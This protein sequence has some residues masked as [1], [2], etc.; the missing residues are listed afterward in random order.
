MLIRLSIALSLLAPLVASAQLDPECGTTA[1]T[2]CPYQWVG[3]TSVAF[4]GSGN[5]L[6]FVG[7]T[8]QCRADF[9]PG[10]RMCKSEEVMDSDTLIFSAIPAEGCWVRPS[11]RPIS[12]GSTMDESG[13]TGSPGPLTC[14][15]W[16]S[17]NGGPALVLAPTGSVTTQYPNPSVPGNFIQTTCD[18]VRPVACCKPTPIPT[19][20]SSLGVPIGA[21]GLVG[22]SMLRG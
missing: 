6:G 18:V 14:L 13:T 8:T 20:T 5:G 7:L 15:S 9:G 19:P 16:T 10:A 17:A 1:A 12:A 4:D 2:M 22:L 3:A 21:L 11:W